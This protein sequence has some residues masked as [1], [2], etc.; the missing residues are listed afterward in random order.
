LRRLVGGFFASALSLG[1]VCGATLIVAAAPAS[2][3]G[4]PPTITENYGPA[5]GGSYPYGGVQSIGYTC[6]SPVGIAS[7]TAVDELG[8]SVP[9]GTQVGAATGVLPGAYSVTIT[10]IDNNGQSSTLTISYT[11]TSYT[12]AI[13]FTSTPPSPALYGGTYTVTAT[14]G[15]SGSPVTF[16]AA[17]MSVCTV[18]GSLVTFTGVGTCTLLANQAGSP[19]YSAAPQVSQG[20]TVA[21][22]PLTITASSSTIFYGQAIPAVT[23]SYGGFVLGQT[24]S[25]LTTQPTCVAAAT[26][27]SNAGTYATSCPGAVDP[28]YAI[29]LV[30][31]SLVIKPA[32]TSL[33]ATP[34]VISVLPLF[35]F[36]FTLNA[37]LISNITGKAIAG[38]PLS[39]A[40]G[41]AFLCSAITNT[42]GVG[43]CSALFR[44]TTALNTILNDG[45]NVN[46]FGSQNYLPS[47]GSARLIQVLP[48]LFL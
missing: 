21:P 25:A 27:A 20:I 41:S 14:G 35:P 6:S 23:P 40:A 48:G 42:N 22:A 38:Q 13:T 7:C 1:A 39:F 47:Q 26:I 18:S 4:A 15:S 3:A 29:T 19:I 9:S 8:V 32:P 31:G 45:Y 10:A 2:A 28:N 16:A 11:V 36:L 17:A 44:N 33:V 12:Q 37:G 30:N 5:N 24:A 34:A 43:T 46:F